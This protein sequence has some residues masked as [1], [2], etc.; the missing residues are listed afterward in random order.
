MRKRL[1]SLTIACI[2]I[3]SLLLSHVS[4]ILAQDWHGLAPDTDGDGLLDDLEVAGWYDSTGGPFHTDPLDADS[5]ND[6]L[7]DGEEKLF[8]TDPLDDRSPGL[9]VR[10]RDGYATIEYFRTDDPAYISM[11]Q[12]GDRHLM[13]E[14]MVVRRGTALLIGGSLEGSLSVSGSGLDPLSP[15]KDVDAGG[16]W[17]QMPTTAGGT[18]GT[19]TATLS[20]PGEGP[21]TLPIYVIFE[22]PETVSSSQWEYNLSQEMIEATLY[23][24]DPA[25]VRDE[26][27]VIWYT[28]ATE[29]DYYYSRRCD[30]GYSPPCY[31]A[32]DFYARKEGWAQA[33]FTKQ[34]AKR[35]FLDRVMWRIQGLRDQATAADMLSWGADEEVRV[36]YW[37]FIQPPEGQPLSYR[38]DSVLYRWED[39][40]GQETQDGWP[41]LSQAGVLTSFLRSAGIPAQAFIAD[42]RHRIYDTSAMAWFSDEGY[43]GWWGVRSYTGGEH[44]D[45]TWAKYY[46]FSRGY[47]GHVPQVPL[48]YWDAQ[49]GYTEIDDLALWAANENWDWYM[50]N[51]GSVYVDRLYDANDDY[52]VDTIEPLYLPYKHPGTHT[53]NA[54]VWKGYSWLP[55]GWPTAYR[56]PSPYPGGDTDENWPIDPIALGCPPG[57]PD[58]PYT[59]TAFALEQASPTAQALPSSADYVRTSNAVQIGEV[60]EDAALDT[61]EDGQLDELVINIQIDVQKPGTYMVGGWLDMPKETTAYGGMY[62]TSKP[63]FLQRGTHTLTLHF[64]A[65][66]IGAKG[67]DGLLRLTQLW[68]TDQADFDP[69]L[70]DWEQLLAISPISYVLSGY[71]A[72]QFEEPAA[73]LANT[74]HDRGIDVDADGR[75][76]SLAVSVDLDV[77]R[78][79]TFHVEADLYDARDHFVGHATWSGSGPS[80]DLRFDLERTRPPY[81]L[82]NLWLLGA[83][84]ALFDSRDGD[85]YRI[86]DLSTRVDRGPVSLDLLPQTTDLRTPMGTIITPTQVFGQRV[87]DADGDGTYDQLFV[88]VQVQVSQAGTYRVE[89]WL[90]DP[91]G[92]LMLYTASAPTSLGTGLQSLSLPFDG[93]AIRAHAVDGP[94]ALIGL[95]ILA[96]GAYTVLDELSVTGLAL[97]YDAAD[98]DPPSDVAILFD[99]DMED[100]TDHWTW[101][102]PWSLHNRVIP[103]PSQLWLARATSTRSGSLRTTEPLD[104]SDYAQPLLRFRNSYALDTHDVASVEASVNGVDWTPLATFGDD[105]DRGATSWVDLS[106]F[107]KSASLQFRFRADAE[108]DLSWFVDDVRLYGWPGVSSALFS[109]SPTFVAPFTDITFVA[110]YVSIDSSLPVTYTWDFG[111]GTP[112]RVTHLPTTV[113]QYPVSQDYHVTLSVE[114][115]YDSEATT[116]IVGV[117]EPVTA[118]HFD[119][120]PAVPEV[121]DT[122][123]FV[124]TY[125]PLDA[126]NTPTTPVSFEWNFGDGDHLITQVPTVTHSFDTGGQ[127][128]VRLITTNS[129]GIVQYHEVVDVKEALST[130]S[131]AS[132]PAAPME[133][134]QVIFDVE[135]EPDTASRPITFTWDF[136]DGTEPLVTNAFTATHVFTTFG[137]YSVQVSAFNGYGIPVTHNGGLFISGRPV[138][139]VSFDQRQ[140]AAHSAH[141]TD[142]IAQYMPANATLPITYT[143]DFGDGAPVQ[144][145]SLP[146][147]THTFVPPE[148]PYTFTVTLTVTNDWG[149]PV[150][151]SYPLR[152]PFDDDGDGLTNAEE[153]AIGTD[154]YDPDTDDD[155]LTDG[156][157]VNGL[158]YEGYPSH[159]DY[160]KVIQTDPLD[161][162]SDDDGLK[163]GDEVTLGAHPLDP[164]TDDDRIKD[165][166]EVDLAYTSPANPDT[167]GDGIDDY[168]EVDDDSDPDNTFDASRHPDTDLDGIP[169][170]L[171]LEADGDGIPDAGEWS[172]DESD[173]LA[174]CS[175]TTPLCLNNDVN[176][177]GIWNFRDLDSD[178][179]AAP[180][181]EEFDA[182]HNT[183]PDDSNEDGIPDWIDH[184]VQPT[185]PYSILLP[186]ILRTDP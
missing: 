43:T 49:V 19:Y 18:V 21:L 64:D 177:D 174:G 160:G 144:V 101:A 182:D 105:L 102:S 115:P 100:G 16:W 41:C 181:S 85:V 106:S 36:D 107:G 46:P 37:R 172:S 27:A 20:L 40:T 92:A 150:V 4:P 24:D 158:L 10:Y 54:V 135:F 22:L 63:V 26:T 5:D 75:F 161:P 95:R 123:T 120:Q 116:L 55:E 109:Y 57:Y 153:F 72:S 165:G 175:V 157:E 48:S 129:Y 45:E 71:V 119:Y 162:D 42:R 9:Y 93:D 2:W 30:E 184:L 142:L 87:V 59:T 148:L 164:D 50:V 35:I 78:P 56:L 51:T 140:T 29:G 186:L 39:E 33:F 82:T 31:D 152:L 112:L 151:Y 104:I 90:A 179:D 103:V 53:L 136:D 168:T 114:N 156:E 167:D 94:Y 122:I 118:T 132:E 134:D 61:D 139:S 155:D 185:R 88:D 86:S 98:F 12:A 70:S 99:D 173:L 137:T 15:Q 97:D 28:F 130:V 1:V 7:G 128:D 32:D 74:F 183:V 163:D 154:P 6:G 121:H 145:T 69:R 60:L 126:T 52:S 170:A 25:D 127:F 58:C 176:G 38:I 91:S 149:A 171:D 124:A 131:F 108:D 147:I 66:S 117:G 3:I 111:D 146:T 159:S 14:A 81:Q 8:D 84:G 89:G 11:R 23:N 80:A 166:A 110:D 125:A 133:H 62:G 169:D 113:H 138:N 44:G 96:G 180:D 141:Q 143:W 68:V 76:E 178:G 17:V 65:E 47:E 67:T 13:T 77:S 79:G 73:L 34:Y 83:D